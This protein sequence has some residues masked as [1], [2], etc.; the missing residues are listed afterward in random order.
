MMTTPAELSDNSVMDSENVQNIGGKLG[1]LGSPP[2]AARYYSFSSAIEFTSR[3]VDKYRIGREKI[4][5]SRSITFPERFEKKANDLN[6]A[7]FVHN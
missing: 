5:N 7:F 4:L 3:A 1:K 6:R 2:D